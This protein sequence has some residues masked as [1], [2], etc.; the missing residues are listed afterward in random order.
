MFSLIELGLYFFLPPLF[1]SINSLWLEMKDFN[2]NL[3]SDGKPFG[4]YVTQRCA[5]QHKTFFFFSFT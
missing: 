4:V 3:T 5:S 2:S 1:M